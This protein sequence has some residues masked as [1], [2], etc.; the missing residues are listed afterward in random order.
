M[1]GT[2]ATQTDS[3]GLAIRKMYIYTAGG[4]S[5]AELEQ[6][7]VQYNKHISMATVYINKL[8]LI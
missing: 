4:L 5:F 6:W 3:T 2:L 1:T 8:S 7:P